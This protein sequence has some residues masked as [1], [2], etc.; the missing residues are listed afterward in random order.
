MCYFT[1]RLVD[2][3]YEIAEIFQEDKLTSMEPHKTLDLRN[4]TN[5]GIKYRSIHVQ[6]KCVCHK[7]I[8]IFT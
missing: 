1:P 4:K 8:D 5:S 2:C 6:Y 3:D 7:C